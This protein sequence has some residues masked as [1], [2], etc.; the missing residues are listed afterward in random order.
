M[1][2][3]A[4]FLFLAGTTLFPQ[5]LPPPQPGKVV[6]ASVPEKDRPKPNPMASDPTAAAA[7]QKLFGEH[8]AICHGDQAQGGKIGPPLINADVQHATP[9]EI[10]WVLTNGVVR[11]GMPSW[12][13]LPPPERWQLVTFLTA[14]N[15]PNKSH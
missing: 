9:G 15:T 2:R 5:Q 8:C 1:K 7:G 14:L 12:S 6:F 4:G 3:F 13:K 11:H 10:F